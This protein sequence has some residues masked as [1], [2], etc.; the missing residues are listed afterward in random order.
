MIT[1]AVLV[2]VLI[3]MRRRYRNMTKFWINYRKFRS[4]ISENR[5]LREENVRLLD[6]KKDMIQTILYL[7]Q[8]KNQTESETREN[9]LCKTEFR[10]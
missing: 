4:I 1:E 5:C 8:K 10:V 6:W 2:S 3:D 9:E 7:K